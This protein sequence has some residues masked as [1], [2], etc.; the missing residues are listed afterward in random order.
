MDRRQYL[1]KLEG[2]EKILNQIC[3]ICGADT[4]N[5]NDTQFNVSY[6][7]CETCEFIAKD[8]NSLVSPE[9]EKKEYDLHNNSYQNEGYVNMFRDFLNRSVID[10]VNNGKEALDF[11]SGPEPVLAKVLSDEYGYTT[12]I[13]DLYYS[14]ERVFEG[15][16]YD[17]ITSTE[18][19]EHL[20]NPLEYFSIFKNLLKEDG[21]LAIMTVFHPQDDE[22]FCKWYYRR[23]KTHISFYT[24]KTM[25][26]IAQILDLELRYIDGKRYCTFSLK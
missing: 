1:R 17:L 22:K 14:P 25:E 26:Y 8:E 18:V 7:Y 21:I 19:V 11:G 13:Y 15:K 5:F 10:F 6:H 3:K 20:K 4:R 12:D 23:D 16:K 2:G 9:E 24:P